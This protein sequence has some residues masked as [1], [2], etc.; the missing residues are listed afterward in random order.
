MKLFW[1]EVKD[2][3][4]AT[5]AIEAGASLF[6]ESDEEKF[7]KTLEKVSEKTEGWMK[8]NC[9]RGYERR[10]VKNRKQPVPDSG[11]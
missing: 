2:K 3:E 5:A 8:K 9:W 10:F 7:K 4:T 11:K 6:V 1:V